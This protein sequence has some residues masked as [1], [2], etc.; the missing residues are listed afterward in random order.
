[1]KIKK[2]AFIGTSCIG[3]TT[4]FE[5]YRKKYIGNNKVSFVEEAARTFFQNNPHIIDRFTFGVQ[6]QIQKIALN[7]EKYAHSKNPQIIF[8]D[9][10]VV[11]A[12]AYMLVYGNKIQA[13]NLLERVRPWL[14]TYS[15]LFLLDPS[16]ILYSTDEIRVESK[17][18]RQ[19]FHKA[20][21]DLF[22]L[23]KINYE[24]L[25]GPLKER[26]RVVDKILV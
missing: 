11:D 1:M 26:V 25:S 4:I 23:N 22:K 3:K 10:S 13:E 5:Y 21:L 6:K 14:N 9:R 12:V 20:F 18:T 16:D 15:R 2:I 8:C 17:E 24:L 7:N 19:K